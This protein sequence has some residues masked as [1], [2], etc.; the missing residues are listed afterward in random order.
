MEPISTRTFCPTASLLVGIYIV[1]VLHFLSPR[2]ATLGLKSASV[3]QAL[4]NSVFAFPLA[5]KCINQA[6][7]NTRYVENVAS[8]PQTMPRHRDLTP[9]R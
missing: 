5:G 3:G 9:V 6:I 1:Q 4:L 7:E 8:L 2:A